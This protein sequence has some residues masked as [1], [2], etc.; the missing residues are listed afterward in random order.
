MYRSQAIYK[1]A[2]LKYYVV[3]W[4]GSLGIVLVAAVSLVLLYEGDCRQGYKLALAILPAVHV[5]AWLI[6]ANF[7]CAQFMVMSNAAGF[8]K[9]KPGQ[10]SPHPEDSEREIPFSKGEKTGTVYWE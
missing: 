4:F 8:T 3:S 6:I 2:V 9:E 5:V 10:A 7:M 1:E